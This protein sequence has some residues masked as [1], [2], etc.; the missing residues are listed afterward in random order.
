LLASQATSVDRAAAVVGTD[1]WAVEEA[2][3]EGVK[4]V[5]GMVVV[6]ASLPTVEA[7]VLQ[8][9]VSVVRE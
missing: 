3:A 4:P 9:R 2:V 1:A 7:E 6:D 8:Q 5:T